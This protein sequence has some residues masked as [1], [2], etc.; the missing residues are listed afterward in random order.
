MVLRAYSVHLSHP[1]IP[2]QSLCKSVRPLIGSGHSI[3][4]VS[5]HETWA[6]RRRTFEDFVG[7]G[8]LGQLA[9][10]LLR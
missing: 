2:L 3:K 9:M 5:R 4:L 7:A 6:A 8:L 10:A 1:T